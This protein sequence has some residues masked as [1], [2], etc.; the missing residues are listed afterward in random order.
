[1]KIRKRRE[2]LD[3]FSKNGVSNFNAELN[4]FI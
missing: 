1:M 4:K 3:Y 2:I